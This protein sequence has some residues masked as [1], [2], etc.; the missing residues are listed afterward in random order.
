MHFEDLEEFMKQSKLLFENYPSKTRFVM[1]YR[2]T[3][4]LNLK[5]TNDLKCL[6]YTT[7]TSRD[8]KKI[9]SFVQFMMRKMAAN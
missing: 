5:V 6:Q 9:E 2:Q 7:T 8:F 1:K 4:G 3:G